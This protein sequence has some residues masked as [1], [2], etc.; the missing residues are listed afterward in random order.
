VIAPQ[1][2]LTE[3]EAAILSK[4]WTE[5]QG[6]LLVL[7]DPNANTPHLRALLE[8][9]GIEPVND[10]VLRLVRLPFAMGILR[11][12]TAEYMPKNPITKRLSGDLMFPGVTQS[13]TADEAKAKAANVQL[14]P[15]IIAKEDF[16]GEMD[17]V[18]D[19]K[20]GVRY[21]EGR[22]IGQ[23]VYVAMAAACGGVNDDRV[24]VE[25]SKLVAVGSCEFAW[26]GAI[27]KQAQ[28]LDFLL[29]ATNWL[30]DRRQLT[31]GIPKNIQQFSLN[32]T[33]HQVSSLSFYTLIVMPGA[34]ALLGIVA[35]LRRR[36]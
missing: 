20:H 19:E 34:V 14:W 18:T 22:D 3:R 32:L 26:D 28:S 17:Y 13:L 24:E 36:S 5:T 10:R 25:S 23:P 1:T 30:L 35:W 15:L 29:S 2:D 9:T 8:S 21:D 33:D 12:V 31:G 27:S 7:L 6:R 4:Y 16:W 11:E